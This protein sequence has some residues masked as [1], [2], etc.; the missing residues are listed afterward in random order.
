MPQNAQLPA[1]RPTQPHETAADALRNGRW[2]AAGEWILPAAVRLLCESIDRAPEP[3]TAAQARK[4]AALLNERLCYELTIRL[5]GAWNRGPRFDLVLARRQIQALINLEQLDDAEALIDAALTRASAPQQNPDEAIRENEKREILG[6]RARI[7]KDRYVREYERGSA[8]GATHDQAREAMLLNQA[9]QRYRPLYKAD[10]GAW[11]PGVNTIAL[12]A[13]RAR[14]Q[15]STQPPSEA[16]DLALSL[17]GELTHRLERHRTQRERLDDD[18]RRLGRHGGT[19][20]GLQSAENGWAAFDAELPWL[21]ASLSECYLAVPDQCQ[22]AELWLYRFLLHPRTQPFHLSSYARQLREIWQAHADPQSCYCPSLLLAILERRHSEATRSIT[23][24]AGRAVRLHRDGALERDYSGE[25]Q[26]SLHTLTKMAAVCA[27][28][29]RVSRASDD[30]ARGTG[31]LLDQQVLWPQLPSELV[32]VTN[33]HVISE[34]VDDALR[35]SEVRIRFEAAAEEPRVTYRVDR[36]LFHSEPGELGELLPTCDALDICIVRLSPSPVGLRGLKI[37]SELP[38]RGPQT[39]AYV[40]GHPRGR[41][42]QISLHDSRLLDYDMLPRL[43]HYRTP[44]EPGSSGSPVF[45][46]HW[47][48]IGVH[49][50]GCGDTPRLDCKGTYEA[51]EGIALAALRRQIEQAG[52]GPP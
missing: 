37:A 48:V 32:F 40:V 28:I 41:P 27:S 30:R 19:P 11:W 2:P 50:A 4:A 45:D 15:S 18:W 51:N 49:H 21:F 8:A 23:L 16:I 24:N 6:L 47:D 20:T 46:E 14:E 39:R 29:G 43:I 1:P 10:S 33:A 25:N 31:F 35:P 38:Q 22:E 3:L 34:S 17:I 7:A 5:A 9:L 44:T 13:R 52:S 42:L 36:I 26:F 12:L